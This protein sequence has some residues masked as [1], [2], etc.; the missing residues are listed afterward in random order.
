MVYPIAITSTSSFAKMQSVNQHNDTPQTF[1]CE[2]SKS[3]ISP[4]QCDMFEKDKFANIK[5]ANNG[6]RDAD[7]AK[8]VD[9]FKNDDIA[10]FNETRKLPDGYYLKSEK[11]VT[12]LDM[13]SGLPAGKEPPCLT[14]V[15]TDEMVAKHIKAHGHFITNK[16]P[17]RYNMKNDVDGS[18]YLIPVKCPTVKKAKLEYKKSIVMGILEGVGAFAVFSAIGIG[19]ARLMGK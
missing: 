2:H 8:F 4:L 11:G 19:I 17:K 13:E 16:I 10:K 7:Y 5:L 3:V 1:R 12:Y 15:K 14:L 18:T 6:N 9:K